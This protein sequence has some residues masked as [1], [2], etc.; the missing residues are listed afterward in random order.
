MTAA[1]IYIFN[2]RAVPMVHVTLDACLT[3][4]QFKLV[5][6]KIDVFQYQHQHHV[7]KNS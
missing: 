6:E 3:L 1:R 2:I 5:P 4:K 7:H